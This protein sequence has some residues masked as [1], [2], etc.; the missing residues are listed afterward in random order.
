VGHVHDAR[1]LR[2]GPIQGLFGPAYRVQG[3]VVGPASFGSRL[4]YARSTMRGP[5]LVRALMKALHRRGRFVEWEA[6]AA[7]EPKLI[8]LRTKAEALPE[9]PSLEE[10]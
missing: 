10:E 4:G 5:A 8:R 2:D 3:L 9:V 6:I 7:I 1:L